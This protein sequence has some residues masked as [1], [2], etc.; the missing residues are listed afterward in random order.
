MLKVKIMK[1]LYFASR[2]I[3][4]TNSVN[5]VD[6]VPTDDEMTISFPIPGDGQTLRFGVTSSFTKTIS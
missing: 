5:D 1:T 3:N 6:D 4:K 2:F